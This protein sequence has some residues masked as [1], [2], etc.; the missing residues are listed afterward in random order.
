[1]TILLFFP[2]VFVIAVIY[3]TLRRETLRDIALETVKFFF[4]TSL[5]SAAGSLLIFLLVRN[6]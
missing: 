5:C 6:L 1:M 3:S 4:L 2:I